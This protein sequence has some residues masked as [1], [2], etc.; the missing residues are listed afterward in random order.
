MLF[1][2]GIFQPPQNLLVRRAEG[3]LVDL[4]HRD[5]AD[6]V[7]LQLL[8]CSLPDGRMEQGQLIQF[9]GNVRVQI[10]VSYNFSNPVNDQMIL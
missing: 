8:G 2:S 7:V 1:R 4:I 9:S 3:I 10:F 6:I 5:P